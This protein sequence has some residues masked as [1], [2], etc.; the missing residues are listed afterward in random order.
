MNRAEDPNDDD[1]DVEIDRVR[2]GGRTVH[3]ILKSNKSFNIT[4]VSLCVNFRLGL[5]YTSGSFRFM[6]SF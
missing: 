6:K 3:K 2:G 5:T 4:C 1:D